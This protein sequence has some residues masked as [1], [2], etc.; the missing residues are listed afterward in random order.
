MWLWAVLFW[1]W[2]RILLKSTPG[3]RLMIS[4][5]LCTAS[6][7]DCRHSTCLT[8]RCLSFGKTVQFLVD[9]TFCAALTLQKKQVYNLLG[10]NMSNLASPT[11]MG[12]FRSSIAIGYEIAE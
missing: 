3:L 9:Q 7:W 6:H 10:C 2:D 5:L 1:F 8:A 12:E 11:L 4:L